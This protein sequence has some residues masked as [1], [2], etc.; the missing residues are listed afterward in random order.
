MSKEIEMPEQRDNFIEESLK[1]DLKFK[2]MWL[3]LQK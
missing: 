2:N 1:K 3:D